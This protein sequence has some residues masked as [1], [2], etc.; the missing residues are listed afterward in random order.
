M[1]KRD[2]VERIAE[3]SL[4]RIVNLSF[5][6]VLIASFVF[7]ALQGNASLAAA[8]EQQI[9]A[10]QQ[11]SELSAAGTLNEVYNRGWLGSDQNF[12]EL[13]AY[14]D[15]LV[16]LAAGQSLDPQFRRE[17]S[18]YIAEN[19]AELPQE[20]ARIQGLHF[21]EGVLMQ[22][23]DRLLETYQQLIIVFKALDE[24]LANWDT[25]TPEMRGE[26]I[27]S[28]QNALST[29]QVDVQATATS[30]QEVQKYA[31]VLDAQSQQ[32][33]QSGPD[34]IQASRIRVLASSLGLVLSVLICAYGVIL[35]VYRRRRGNT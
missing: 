4:A 30:A 20:I 2:W 34:G 29:A 27:I 12:Y 16:N 35:L 23:Q 11:S 26:Q 8:G 22:H 7:L 32:A 6:I 1:K 13:A 14:V 10:A 19:R 18:S 9:S 31:G 17:L 33:Y 24:I 21:S 25:G 28:I 5:S 3:S 15:R